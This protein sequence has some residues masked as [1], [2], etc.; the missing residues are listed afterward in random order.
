MIWRQK[1]GFR[2]LAYIVL[3]STAV[4]LIS[5]ATQLYLDYRN[6]VR[7]IEARL[8]DI[9]ESYADSLAAG[10]WSIDSEQL[11]LQVEGIVRLPDM[12][13]AEVRELVRNDTRPLVITAGRR[14]EHAVI[15]RE[16]PLI[17]AGRDGSERIG[18]FYIEGT[19]DEVYDRLIDAALVIL[20]S[21]GVMTFLVS[22]FTLFIFHRLV[23]RHLA[24][25]ARFFRSHDLRIS[26]PT[27]ELNRPGP[28][29]GD[30]LDHMVDAINT[31]SGDLYTAN[32]ELSGLNTNL[33]RDLALRAAKE[34][35][36]RQ[37]VREL[38]RANAELDRFAY[39]ASH[40]LQEPLRTITSFAQLLERKYKG[41]LDSEACEYIEFTVTAAK[42]MHALIN[43]LLV[44][45]RINANGTPFGP[46]STEAAC[47]AA[48][49]NLHQAIA[50]SGAEISVGPLPE[51]QGDEAQLVQVF[52]NLLGNAIK[53]HRPGQ[54]PHVRIEAQRIDDRWRFSVA[55]DGIG[56]TS[57]HGDIFEIFRRLHTIAEFPGT[58]VGLAICKSIIL[59]H[60]GEIWYESA[61]GIGST[62][63][64]TLS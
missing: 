24:D 15:S 29:L 9:E 18:T 27:L 8:D 46:A 19:L 51:V 4:T 25:I 37:T 47:A 26:S 63:Y 6:Q 49:D 32:C 55:D 7:S 40:D 54:T 58:G 10:L 39:V 41:K 33:E 36:L 13:A 11:R 62:F 17:H 12:R 48:I 22:L 5:S 52:Q 56:I 53:F 16:I 45:S 1:I 23:T 64:F 61:A 42:R 28:P 3:F 43:D 14:Q 60:Q 31:M 30:E 59:H 21:Q 20:V 57:E 34:Q 50:E 35:E 38:E 2:L 44:Y